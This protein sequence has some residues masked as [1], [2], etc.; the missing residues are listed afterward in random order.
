MRSGYFQLSRERTELSDDRRHAYAYSLHIGE[1]KDLQ[2][3]AAWYIHGLNSFIRR[4]SVYQSA[5]ELLLAR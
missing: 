5:V 3:R 2:R 4:Q 1:S